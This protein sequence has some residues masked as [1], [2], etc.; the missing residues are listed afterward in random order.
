MS[1]DG[2]SDRLS[3]DDAF[4]TLGNETRLGILQALGRAEGDLS[5]SE[6]RDRV[7][8]EDSGQFNYH[9]EQLVGHFVRKTEGGYQLR[10]AGRRVVEAVLSG[11]VTDAPDL[12]RTPVEE[13]CELCGAPIEV[14]RDGGSIA[15]YCTECAGR[16]S[17]AYGEDPT[18][19]RADEGYLGR[20]PLPPAGVRDR[21]PTEVMRAAWTWGNLEILAISAGI[22]P[23]CSATVDHTLRVCEDHDASDGLCAE[24]RGRQ[25]VRLTVSCTNCIFGSGGI[26]GINLVSNTH[27][28]DLLTDHGLNPVVPD[29]IRRVNEVHGDYEE[30][31]LSTEPFRARF[32]FDVDGDTLALTVDDDLEVVE[33]TRPGDDS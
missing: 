29:S 2:D 1:G 14:A 4:A 25:A 27:L 7:G 5:F 8:V 24:C 32:T 6:L 17:H 28:I 26:F 16:Y 13:T 33:A 19:R 11:A 30:D 12:D 23:R 21:T 22:C 9:L 3:P 15:M 10:R 31:L 18:G 20:L